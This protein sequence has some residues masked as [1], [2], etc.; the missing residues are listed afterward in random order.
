MDIRNCR[1]C[2]KLFSSTGSPVCSG[3]TRQDQEDFDKVR[4]FLFDHPNSTILEIAKATEVDGKTISRFLKEGRLKSDLILFT[5]EDG[6]TCEKCG[7]PITSGRFC[8]KCVENLKAEL[9]QAQ[10]GANAPKTIN[11]NVINNGNPWQQ[12]KVHTYEHIVKKK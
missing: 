2:G 4:D 1:R 5:E 9:S 8:Q 6:F 3:C 11:N 10:S 12:S 7:T